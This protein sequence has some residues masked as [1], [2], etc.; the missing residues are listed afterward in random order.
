[1]NINGLHGND[2]IV[3]SS[4]TNNQEQRQDPSQFPSCSLDLYDN[5]IFRSLQPSSA[6]CALEKLTKRTENTEL[7][8]VTKQPCA[9]LPDLNLQLQFGTMDDDEFMEI[10][11][12]SQ[13]LVAEV[14]KSG[15][16]IEVQLKD[17]L[18]GR[19]WPTQ[20]KIDRAL[21]EAITFLVSPSCPDE[22][23]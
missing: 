1:V 4:S 15:G 13:Y 2:V 23:T 17:A 3:E 7:P 21:R 9:G 8:R 19:P 20:A 22:E 11:F 12:Q 10:R 5:Q 18:K 6:S 14:Y 16:K